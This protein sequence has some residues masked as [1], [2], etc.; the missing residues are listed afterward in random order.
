[1]QSEIE[2]STWHLACVPNH[3][4]FV[5]INN[6]VPKKLPKYRALKYTGKV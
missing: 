1:M 5:R 3:K 6:K 2:L 4:M